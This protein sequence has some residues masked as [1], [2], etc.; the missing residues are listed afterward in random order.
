MFATGTLIGG[1]G[2]AGRCTITGVTL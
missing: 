1:G 2:P